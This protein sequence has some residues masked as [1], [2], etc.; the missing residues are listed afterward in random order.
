M[1]VEKCLDFEHNEHVS[2]LKKAN[3]Y[4][5]T[6]DK[7]VESQSEEVFLMLNANDNAINWQQHETQ[8]F[9]REWI[10]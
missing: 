1:R 7:C 5:S 10:E 3:L 2:R 6:Q 8:I 4:S 9:C